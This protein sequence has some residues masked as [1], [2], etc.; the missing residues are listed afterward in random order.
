MDS[1]VSAGMDRI[2]A[3]LAAQAGP[4]RAG[5]EV[6][7]EVN[8]GLQVGRLAGALEQAERRQRLLAM[9]I[10]PVDIG[11]VAYQVASGNP[12]LAPY[13]SSSS[14][15]SPQ[16]GLI[17]DVTRLSVAGLNAGDMV[18]LYRPAGSMVA[19][20]AAAVHTFLCPAGVAAGLG[21]ADWEPS[22][23]GLIMRP[24]DT[25]TLASAGTLAATNIVISGQAIQVDLRVLADYLM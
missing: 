3:E 23:H 22:G 25:F 20:P 15:M 11:P 5:I 19:V 17:W 1:T 7:A 24:D 9:C 14:D 21:I 13:R 2:A 8:L 4:P 18:N 6:G 16:E 12:T 10:T